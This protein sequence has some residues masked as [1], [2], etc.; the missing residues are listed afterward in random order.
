MRL[1]TS[2]LAAVTAPLLFFAWFV[3]PALAVGGTGQLEGAIWNLGL[4]PPTSKL[5][6]QTTDK[7]ALVTIYGGP[8]KKSD[9]PLIKIDAVLIAKCVFDNNPRAVRAKIGFT[10]PQKANAP[11]YR[12]RQVSV[13]KGDIKAFGSKQI[14]KADLLSSLEINEIS[15]PVSTSKPTMPE[16]Q[17]DARAEELEVLSTTGASQ[18]RITSFRE[19]ITGLTVGYPALW[20]LIEKPDKETLFR[21]ESPTLAIAF[22]QDNSSGLPVKQFARLWQTVVLPQLP[23]F[24]LISSNRIKIGKNGSIDALTSVIQFTANDI[25]FKQRWIFFGQTG[26]VLHAVITIPEGAERN[27]I[28]DLNKMLMSLTFTGG[29]LACVSAP[30]PKEPQPWSSMALFQDGPI[31]I[32]Y[33]QGWQVNKRPEPDVIA[34][35][36][37]KNQDGEADL[38]VRRNPIDHNITLE[39]IALSLE[40]NYLKQ[41]KNY[42]RIRQEPIGLTGSAAGIL[43]E[44]TFEVSGLPFRQI[45]A[46]RHEG[47]HLY[48]L[49]LTAF[50][51]K[52]SEMLTLFNR[53][54]GTWI[55]RE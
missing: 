14:S 38:E 3:P 46:Y 22:G 21:I 28:P 5:S 9:D 35:I 39:E 36:H 40:T 42:R 10:V 27:D 44:F 25:R 30:Q 11:S 52:Q 1:R 37:G 55:V 20:K 18:T 48:T 8:Y 34:K 51:W 49:S 13:S 47:D 2:I 50:N 32:N 7:L 53:C 17:T 23:G 6:V 29:T 33:P 54:L 24:K 45:T 31:T 43:Q 19:P 15:Q 26:N 12:V 41:L 4:L 16:K